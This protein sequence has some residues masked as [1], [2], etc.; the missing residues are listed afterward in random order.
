MKTASFLAAVAL[1]LIAGCASAPRPLQ[2][3]T[4]GSLT[5]P[6]AARAQGV[7]GEVRVQYDVD[8]TGTVVNARVV[9]ADPAGTFEQAALDFVLSWRFRPVEANGRPVVVEDNVSEI[10]FRLDDGRADLYP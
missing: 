2:L 6:E 3:L 9:A 10:A 1:A 5:Y 7:E 8:V 4:T